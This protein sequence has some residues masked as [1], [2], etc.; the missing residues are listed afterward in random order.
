MRE[1]LVMSS[2]RIATPSLFGSPSTAVLTLLQYP[3]TLLMT[4]A[5]KKCLGISAE[6]VALSQIIPRE[7]IVAGAV[8][9]GLRCNS[10]KVTNSWD[11]AMAV[12][13]SSTMAKNIAGTAG[14]HGRHPQQAAGCLYLTSL[15]EPRGVPG[16]ILRVTPGKVAT[17]LSG[18]AVGS[19]MLPLKLRRHLRSG[20]QCHRRR[21][22]TAAPQQRRQGR[23]QPGHSI[24]N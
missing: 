7:A 9:A 16:L 5:M 14:T 23:S 11:S 18:T 1:T 2:A 17:S 3:T 20:R 4:G 12:T 22:L 19:V 15:V 24:S 6:R 13:R 10:G 8:S 21:R